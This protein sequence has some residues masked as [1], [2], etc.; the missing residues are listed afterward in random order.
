MRTI[1]MKSGLG[2]IQLSRHEMRAVFGYPVFLPPGE[3]S[4]HYVSETLPRGSRR[5]W[6]NRSSG[7][8]VCTHGALSSGELSMPIYFSIGFSIQPYWHEL[9][10]LLFCLRIPVILL[11]KH[12]FPA[13]EAFREYL[14]SSDQSSENTMSLYATD[15]EE[16]AAIKRGQNLYDHQ[17]TDVGAAVITKSKVALSSTMARRS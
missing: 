8:R 1:E 9:V 14:P 6:K 12:Q 16:A 11:S 17:E 13:L 5:D 4:G 15:D 7:L 3:K 2:R 10:P